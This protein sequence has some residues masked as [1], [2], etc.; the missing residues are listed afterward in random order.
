MVLCCAFSLFLLFSPLLLTRLRDSRAT[1][2]A[3]RSFSGRASYHVGV[4]AAFLTTPEFRL[5]W[6]TRD[7][8]WLFCM[9]RPGSSCSRPSVAGAVSSDG[10]VRYSK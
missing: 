2:A 9:T 10:V 4:R 7:E 5:R 8:F 3:A 6:I 1:P